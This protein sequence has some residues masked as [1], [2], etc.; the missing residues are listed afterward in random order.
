MRREIVVAMREKSRDNIS[1]C[2][3]PFISSS[4][5]YAQRVKDREA[6][7][8]MKKGVSPGC[9]NEK[10]NFPVRSFLLFVTHTIY[11]SIHYSY[12]RD[13][14]SSVKI[15]I[16]HLAITH[17][18]TIIYNVRRAHRLGTH[19]SRGVVSDV[20]FAFLQRRRNYSN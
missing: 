17:S 14:I 3:L 16:F 10:C 1:L 18:S 19:C 20:L 8:S 5:Y 6:E 15:D 9:V 12:R 13:P 7:Q 4:C 11:E 2:N